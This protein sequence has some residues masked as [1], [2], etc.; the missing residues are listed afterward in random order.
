LEN[1]ADLC[2]SYTDITFAKNS[3]KEIVLKNKF[4]ISSG[5]ILK[6]NN[7]I[8]HTENFDQVVYFFDYLDDIFQNV[9]SKE[10][11]R[12]LENAKLITE[13]D[14][15]KIEDPYTIDKLLF[16]FSN[17]LEGK[18]PSKNSP[19]EINTEPK[20]NPAE[21][22]KKYKSDFNYDHWKNYFSVPKI[23]NII[24]EFGWNINTH[25]PYFFKKLIDKYNFSGTGRLN[26]KEFLFFAIWENYRNYAQC[27]HFCFK[28]IIEKK[29][30]PLFSFL[31]CDKDGFINSENI[32]NGF[33]FLKRSEANKD[34]YNYYKCELPK[35][36]NKFYRTHAVNDFVLK[37]SGVADGFL[38]REEFRKGI[39]LGYWERQVE[40]NNVVL[41]DSI[42]RKSE[43]WDNT[44]KEDKDCNDLYK[45]Y[46]VQK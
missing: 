13:E 4:S 2:S 28:D 34:K 32:W 36:F 19:F 1:L 10:F 23:S 3:R 37:N 27:N 14:P 22:I 40:T 11:S 43:R 33:K 5:P 21:L 9:I 31:D 16:Y 20:I 38:N 7:Y 29:I 12:L 6:Y 45:M 26:A 8:R 44:G 41:D 25:T 18:D 15:K 30:D 17:G 39:L 46:H 24:K 35:P 42:N